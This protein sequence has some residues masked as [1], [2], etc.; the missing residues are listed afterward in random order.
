MIGQILILFCTS[1]GLITLVGLIK[2]S[3]VMQ[4]DRN[5]VLMH[6]FVPALIFLLIGQSLLQ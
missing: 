4:K 5:K 3:F 1:L 2:P 6:F